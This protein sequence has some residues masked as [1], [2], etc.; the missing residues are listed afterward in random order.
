MNRDWYP[1]LILCL[2][3]PGASSARVVAEDDSTNPAE[4]AVTADDRE[5]W[6][7]QSIRN[8]KPP[9][10]KDEGWVRTPIDRFVLGRLEAEGLVP[11]SPAS[12]RDLLRRLYLDLIGL[13]PTIAE[14]DAFL[15]D[16]SPENLD[17]EAAKLLKR[18]GYGERWARHWLDLVRYADTNGYERDGTKPEGWRYRDWVI[19]SLNEDKPYDRFVLEQ[20]AGDELDDASPETVIATGFY[21]LGPWD[22]EPAE[23]A[24]DLHDQ[25]DDMIR[26]ISQVYFGLT[27]GC[28]RCHDHKFDALTIYD[29]YRMSAI[30]EP[31]KRPQEGRGE[32]THTQHTRAHTHTHTQ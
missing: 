8:P 14:Q 28:A 4:R 7:Y 24:Q 23:P 5:H 11:A 6:S 15:A 3:I 2:T 29:Y 19:S 1:L 31:L 25:R 21:R 18:K 10:I 22:D 27:L 26:T 20:L 12:P 9:A 32:R 17:R 30:L 16:P 13:P